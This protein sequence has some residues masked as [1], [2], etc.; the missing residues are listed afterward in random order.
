MVTEAPDLGLTH[1]PAAPQR[2]AGHNTPFL[3]YILQIILRSA[4]YREL[5]KYS[6][7]SQSLGIF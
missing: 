6:Q 2:S 1:H 3:A 7:T 4:G 5:L